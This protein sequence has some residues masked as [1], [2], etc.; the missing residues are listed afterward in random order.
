MWPRVELNGGERG[1]VSVR[2]KMKIH[3]NTTNISFHSVSLYKFIQ[4]NSMC[5]LNASG[6][7]VHVT[8]EEYLH[9]E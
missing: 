7:C 8:R 3:C 2:V 5:S 1:K 6:V 4:I 9:V